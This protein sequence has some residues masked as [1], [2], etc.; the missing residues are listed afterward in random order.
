[1]CFIFYRNGFGKCVPYTGKVCSK[2]LTGNQRSS[3]FEYKYSSQ[4][5]VERGLFEEFKKFKKSRQ[6]SDR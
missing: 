5:A 2:Y 4:R 6:F 3:I 1:M